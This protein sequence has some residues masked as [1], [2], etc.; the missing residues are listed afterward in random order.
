M[1]GEVE[2]GVKGGGIDYGL[3]GVRV[4]GWVVL[5]CGIEFSLKPCDVSS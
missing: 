3:D 2:Y 4:K 5:G 1:S